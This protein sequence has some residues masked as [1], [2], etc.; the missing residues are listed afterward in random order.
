MDLEWL[1]DISLDDPPSLRLR[2]ESVDAEAARMVLSGEIDSVSA[3]ELHRAVVEVLRHHRP[4]RIDLDLADVS[5]LDAG[6]TKALVLC[7]SDARQMDCRIRLTNVRPAVYQVLHIT[8]LVEHF[9]V[10]WQQPPPRR[11]V[12]GA[13]VPEGSANAAPR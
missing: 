2:T 6:G 9:G 8:G 13:A 5:F 11:A 4:R 3:G 10:P 12:T 7:Q 1:A